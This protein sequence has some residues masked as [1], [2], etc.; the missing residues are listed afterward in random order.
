MARRYRWL[1]SLYAGSGRGMPQ[2]AG[3]PTHLEHSLGDDKA[4]LLATSGRLGVALPQF[5]VDPG[6]VQRVSRPSTK[7]P[8]RDFSDRNGSRPQDLETIHFG[9][10]YCARAASV[11]GGLRMG[12]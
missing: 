1:P 8:L 3:N 12:R 5:G 6:P 2:L 7:T 4:S 9:L 10:E 11:E